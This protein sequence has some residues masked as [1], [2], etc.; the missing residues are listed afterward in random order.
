[1]NRTT[2]LLPVT[3]TSNDWPWDR[4]PFEKNCRRALWLRCVARLRIEEGHERSDFCLA[5]FQI[6]HLPAPRFEGLGLGRVSEKPLEVVGFVSFRRQRTTGRRA[7]AFNRRMRMAGD[8]PLRDEQP[9]A[10]GDV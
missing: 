1:M 5:Q 9:L 6:G 3:L 8:A 2:S 4:R 10:A 7:T